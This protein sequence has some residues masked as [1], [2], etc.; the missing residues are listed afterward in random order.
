[1]D[2]SGHPIVEAVEAA[3]GNWPQ[4]KYMNVFVC[5]DPDGAAGYTL[6]PSGWL[7]VTG[8]Y[9]SIY[10]RHTYFGSIGTGNYALARAF[11]HEVGHWLNLSHPWGPNNNPGNAASCGDDDGV[12]D[13]PNT[14]GWTSC[15]LSGTT[16]SSLDNVQNFME[17]SYCS[18]MFTAGQAARMNTALQSGQPADRHNLWQNI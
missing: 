9:G 16:C 11:S 14:I 13:T 17:Y 2:L 6:N 15:N 18:R 10:I 12:T 5:I 7:P 3:H 4:N 8:M 1:M